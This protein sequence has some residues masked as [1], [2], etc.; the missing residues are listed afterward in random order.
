MQLINQTNPYKWSNIQCMCSFF[1][2]ACIS[3]IKKK[4]EK[5]QFIKEKNRNMPLEALCPLSLQLY[6]CF[7][8]VY[9]LR[10]GQRV[11]SSWVS[12]EE[13]EKTVLSQLCGACSTLGF[14]HSKGKD[15]CFH[16]YLQVVKAL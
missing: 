15:F 1:F 10:G 8:D 13:T 11:W 12:P 16:Y 2:P 3:N 9:S 14:C 4:K 5:K 6:C 7:D